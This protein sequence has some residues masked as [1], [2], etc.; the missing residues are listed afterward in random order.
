MRFTLLFLSAAV[1]FAAD[2]TFDSK[3]AFQK[4]TT[5]AGQWEGDAGDM[6]KVRLTI[7][8]IAGGTAIVEKE[9]FDHPG[10]PP[11]MTLYHMDGNKLMLTHYC[12]AGNQP[13]LRAATFD[14][15]TGE[16]RWDFQDITNLANPKTGHMHSAKMKIEGSTVY[17]D[18][19]FWEG[20][21]TAKTESFKYV[22]VK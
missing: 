11:M 9:T 5:M 19:N 3:A 8:V 4:L 14:A 2:L 1:V 15:K 21:S 6:G 16:I 10:M 20:G 13:R 7:E 18:W 22:R 12:D 17:S